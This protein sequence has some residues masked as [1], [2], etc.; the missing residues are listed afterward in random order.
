MTLKLNLIIS[1]KNHQHNDIEKFHCIDMCRQFIRHGNGVNP[2]SP[3]RHANYDFTS[4]YVDLKNE[5]NK[6]STLVGKIK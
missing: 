4:F 3:T 5:L 6:H 1:S 2:I